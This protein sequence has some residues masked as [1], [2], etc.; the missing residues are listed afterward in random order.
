MAADQSAAVPH[1]PCPTLP[2][3][4]GPSTPEG[5]PRP[6]GP[7]G[8]GP[9]N[10]S[11][12]MGSSGWRRGAGRPFLSTALG[13]SPQHCTRSGGS[14]GGDG[15]GGHLQSCCICS[16]QAATQTDKDS[17]TLAQRPGCGPSPGCPVSRPHFP[18]WHVKA[19]PS[20]PADTRSRLSSLL[21]VTIAN[22]FPGLVCTL[23]MSPSHR[24]PHPHRWGPLLFRH[25]AHCPLASPG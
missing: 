20:G 12:A 8:E 9:G 2:R 13:V 3:G 21:H 7:R 17:A 10:T 1:P 5:L 24:H 14:G 25:P 22:D 18:A 4:G 6:A 23:Q 19:S 15:G 16:R 11:E